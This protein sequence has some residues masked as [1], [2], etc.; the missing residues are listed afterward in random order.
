MEGKIVFEKNRRT[1]KKSKT[2]TEK[3]RFTLFTKEFY[4]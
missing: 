2:S 4:Y 3:Y 1:E